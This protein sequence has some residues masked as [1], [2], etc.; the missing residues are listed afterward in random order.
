VSALCTG[1]DPE[2]PG[3]VGQVG[4]NQWRRGIQRIGNAGRRGTGWTK[5]RD[6]RGAAP[7]R[8]FPQFC[9]KRAGGSQRTCSFCISP[10]VVNSN[11]RETAMTEIK[12]DR[13]SRRD[14]AHLLDMHPDSVSRILHE[15]LSSAVLEWGGRGKTMTFSRVRVLRWWRARTCTRR[16]GR[17]CSECAFVLEDCQAVGEHLMQ[18]RHGAEESCEDDE[19]GP[20]RC[21]PADWR[22]CQPCGR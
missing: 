18:A 15:G 6:A 8:F 13:I 19:N 12:T 22:V 9:R 3:Q 1:S 11:D 4:P 7:F 2:K 21:Y 14:V 17:P 5:P 16:G 10:S 20:A